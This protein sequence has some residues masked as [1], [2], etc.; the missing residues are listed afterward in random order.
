MTADTLIDPDTSLGALVAERPARAELFEQLRLEYCCGGRQTL[1]EACAAR[2]LDPAAVSAM[3]VAFDAESRQTDSAEDTDWREAGA[4]ALCAHIVTVH[5]DGLREAFP[6]LE[7][8]LSTVVRVHAG[9]EPRL[10]DVER[11]FGEIRASLEPH[12]ASEENELFPA[13]IAAERT[14]TPVPAR[15]LSEHESEHVELGHA[16]VALRILCDGY[17]RD[18]GLCNTHR[19]LLDGLEA[20]EQDLHRHVHEEN[21]IL[22][23]RAAGPRAR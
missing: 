3:L 21:N 16:L 13:C 12:L 23:P 14:G 11:L 19:A 6:R 10:R 4:A 5:H 7:G 20:F 18:A 1:G 22:L 2:A 17:E 15:M 8:L 9:R